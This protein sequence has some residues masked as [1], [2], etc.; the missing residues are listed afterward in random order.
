MFGFGWFL[1]SY[2]LKKVSMASPCSQGLVDAAV[3]VFGGLG[4]G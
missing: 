2:W 1:F 4:T 3:G